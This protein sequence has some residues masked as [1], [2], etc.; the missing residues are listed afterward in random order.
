MSYLKKKTVNNRI[1]LF[2][3]GLVVF[4]LVAIA[5]FQLSAQNIP[6][7]IELKE[8]KST[9]DSRIF[10]VK[11][12]GESEAGVVPVFKAKIDFICIAD[13]KT[14]VL[15]S[16]TTDKEGKSTLKLDKNTNFLTNKEGVSEVKASF[17][18]TG[19]LVSSEASIKFKELNLQLTLEGKDSV[20]SIKL[21]ATTTG[22][23]GEVIPLKETNFNVYVMGLYSKLKVGECFVDAGVGTLEFPNNIPGDENGNL[24]IFVRLEENEVY[25]EVEKIENAKW[26]NHRSG[27]IESERSLWTSGAPIWMI[28]TLIILLAGVWSHYM[29]AIIQMIKIRKEGRKFEK[30]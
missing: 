27:F 13:G 30:N 15:G 11:L 16:V 29:Y 24:K 28:T 20:N 3:Q 26:G 8:I 22:L 23:K 19:K 4:F 5:S 7:T 18:G 9:D 1:H 10:N 6:S 17:I 12:T 2:R 14:N 25:G 21:Q